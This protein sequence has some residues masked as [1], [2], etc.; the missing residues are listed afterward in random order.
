M[1]VILGGR[2]QKNPVRKQGEQDGSRGR[3]SQTKMCFQKSSLSL[4]LQGALESDGTMQ[5]AKLAGQGST[6]EIAYQ[7]REAHLAGPTIGP[8]TIYAVIV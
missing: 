7:P 3:G 5:L 6:P 8:D 4:I 1:Q 2:T